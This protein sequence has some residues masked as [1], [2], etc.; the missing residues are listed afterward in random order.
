MSYLLLCYDREIQFRVRQFFAEHH[1]I[2]Q[3]F[4][5]GS[6]YVTATEEKFSASGP[7]PVVFL[8]SNC[9]SSTD[10]EAYVRELMK[11]IR[12]DSFGDCLQNKDL[13]EK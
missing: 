2:F 13:P 11:F 1:R 5:P 7:A 3:L 8:S 10:R 4:L 6:E 12:V 9:D